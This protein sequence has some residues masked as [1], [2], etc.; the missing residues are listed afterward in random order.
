MENI[1]KKSIK[2]RYRTFKLFANPE[3]LSYSEER[4]KSWEG[5]LSY[6]E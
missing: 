4:V 1:N 5:C 6:L 2:E 3:I